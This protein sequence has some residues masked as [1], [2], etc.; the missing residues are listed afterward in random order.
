MYLPKHFESTDPEL[1][2][3][4]M[5]TYD[6]ATLVNQ[7]DGYPFATHLPV[8]PRRQDDGSF[9]IDAHVAHAN[10]QWRALASDPRAL[11]IFQGPHAYISPTNFRSNRRVPTWNYVAVH[12]RGRVRILESASEKEA[13]LGRLI[14]VQEP[15]FAPHFASFEP[16]LRDSLL[17]AIVG[18]E[19]QVETL[20][21]KFKLN[22]HRLADDRAELPEEFA[23]GDEN[24]RELAKWM[25]RLGYWKVPS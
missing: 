25:Q 4:V 16:Q 14:G 12:A 6:F 2:L 10:P 17:G 1:L 21:G 15:T 19:I 11:V 7:I 3:E 24:H 13:I 18:L 8:L 23:Q 5:R 20:E 9:V 22:Q